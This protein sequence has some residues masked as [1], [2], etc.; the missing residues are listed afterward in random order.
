MVFGQEARSA[1]TSGQHVRSS[2]VALAATVLAAAMFAGLSG[3]GASTASSAS[4]GASTPDAVESGHSSLERG[5][6]ASSS[7][8]MPGDPPGRLQS[9]RRAVL[10]T[11]D[12]VVPDNVTVFD[13]HYPAITNLDPDLQ[14]LRT[15]AKNAEGE[16]VEFYVN[17]GWRSEKYQEQLF[18]Q[19]VSQYG[20]EAKAA[21]WVA[22]PGTSVHE[23]GQAVDLGPDKADEWLSEHGAAYGLCQIYTNE[24][25]HFELRATAQDEGCPPMYADPT[26]DARLQ[27]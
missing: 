13:D 17:S 27:E 18:E 5:G 9:R 26:H 16:G 12:G 6:R 7:T 25:W 20:S 8:A 22:R 11:A 15:A 3:C 4:L 1:R 24:P 19:A 14:A 10:G 23:A 21:R 2:T